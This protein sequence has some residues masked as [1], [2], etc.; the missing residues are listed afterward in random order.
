MKLALK[1]YKTYEKGLTKEQSFTADVIDT[2]EFIK[3]MVGCGI[4]LGF[5]EEQ[6]AAVNLEHFKDI[7]WL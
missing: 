5:D 1:T 7:G 6:L 3:F 4:E 2:T